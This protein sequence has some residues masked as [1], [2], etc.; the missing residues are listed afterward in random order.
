MI[1]DIV[2]AIT[3]ELLTTSSSSKGIAISNSSESKTISVDIAGEGCDPLA[4]SKEVFVALF[5]P[6]VYSVKFQIGLGQ[7]GNEWLGT[8]VVAEANCT[9]VRA[10]DSGTGAGLYA[11]PAADAVEVGNAFVDSA[12]DSVSSALVEDRAAVHVT[13]SVASVC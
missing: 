6:S 8:D 9:V 5:I 7:D 4:V 1:D 2:G 11:A 12:R 13:L 10:A 3:T